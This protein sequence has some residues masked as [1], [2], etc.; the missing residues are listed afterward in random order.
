[1][2][3]KELDVE[4]GGSVQYSC[5]PTEFGGGWSESEECIEGAHE[6]TRHFFPSELYVDFLNT[7][8]L[9]TAGTRISRMPASWHLK[10]QRSKF[11]SDSH[12]ATRYM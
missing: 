7:F 2:L 4:G 11:S 6:G 10:S 3:L 1:M 5:S 8:L 12:E 9:A